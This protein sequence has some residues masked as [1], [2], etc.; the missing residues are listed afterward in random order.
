MLTMCGKDPLSLVAQDL[1][2]LQQGAYA[3]SDS[4]L[5]SGLRVRHMGGPTAWS[6]HKE[7]FYVSVSVVTEPSSSIHL[8]P[9]KIF[10]HGQ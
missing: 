9:S 10:M 5:Y 3:V 1:H 8:C 6:V 2:L 4:V 7:L